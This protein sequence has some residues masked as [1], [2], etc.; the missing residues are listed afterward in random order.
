MKKLALKIM[1]VGA[2]VAGAVATLPNVEFSISESKAAAC[3]LNTG[4]GCH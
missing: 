2:F 4:A 1:A 3:D